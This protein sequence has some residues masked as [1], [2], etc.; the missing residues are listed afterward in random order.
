MWWGQ[1]GR[2]RMHDPS[3]SHS[4]PRLGCRLG[5]FSPSRRQIRS[6]RL[7]L[8]SPPS[9]QPAIPIE[10]RAHAAIAVAAELTR[11]CN[12]RCSQRSLIPWR[13]PN[14][15]LARAPLAEHSTRAAFRHSQ[16]GTDPAHT[17]AA[18]LGAQKFP[19]AASFKISLSSLDQQP[20]VEFPAPVP[21]A[22]WLD[23]ASDRRTPCASDSR[24]A[25]SPDRS[26]HLANL[27]TTSQPYLRLTQLAD[28]LLGCV[29]LPCHL[30]PPQKPPS[31]TSG[32]DRISGRTS[33]LE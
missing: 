4:R 10:Q 13:L 7:W 19:A 29:T 15:A 11:Q 25:H 8:T 16:Q 32:P 1:H 31:L 14:I 5:T 12:D 20:L 26:A 21:S 28:N 22:A 30:L 23:P 3:L 33:H 24:S 9:R 27:A 18:T 17:E 6:T 2:R